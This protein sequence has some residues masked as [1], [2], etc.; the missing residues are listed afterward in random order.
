MPEINDPMQPGVTF[1]Q[2]LIPSPIRAP[3]GSLQYAMMGPFPDLGTASQS[4]A[5][6]PGALIVLNVILFKT[7]TV[8]LTPKVQ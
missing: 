2:V 4:A 3:D 5:S 8:P 1:Y 7:P 6:K